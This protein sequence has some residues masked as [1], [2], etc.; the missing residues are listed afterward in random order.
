[1]LPEFENTSRN[2]WIAF[3]STQ[4]LVDLKFAVPK[5]SE[6]LYMYWI[7]PLGDARWPNLVALHRQGSVFHTP[8]WLE[9][10][11]RT[12]GYRPVALTSHPPGLE[13]LDGIPF[14]VVKSWITGSR[15]VSLPFSDHCQPLLRDQ[16][17][18]APFTECLR[19]NCIRSGWEYI[20]LRLKRPANLNE[21]SHD[22]PAISEGQCEEII[23]F[24]PGGCTSSFAKY[25]EYNFHRI[26]LRPDVDT[27]FR[28]FHKSCVQRK[29]H[30]AER[31][32]LEYEAGRSESNMMKFYRLLVMT[33]RRHGVPPQPISWFRN[34]IDCFGE[35]LTIHIA[36]KDDRPIAAI[37]T[38]L[39]R[40]TLVYKYGCSDA[41]FHRLG[42][43]PMLF[44][45]ALQKGK[46]QDVEEF[47]LGRSNRDNPGLAVFKER[48]GAT[49]SKLTYSRLGRVQ[50]P[51]PPPDPRSR[52]VNVMFA[53]MPSRVAQ[54][55]GRVMY[56]H[57]G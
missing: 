36:S 11:R 4:T 3:Q 42:A 31:E 25:A 49:R 50:S 20:E 9:A 14:C 55:A 38:L 26:D 52:L 7:N 2:E 13:L 23:P 51:A 45:K 22:N 28:N 43:M 35:N 53:R 37:L 44:W 16:G 6:R 18:L 8:S 46:Q 47:D 54:M 10:L 21:Q 30:R 41:A 27:L 17:D 39:Y 57:I 56:R 33:R 34:L 40:K 48:L 5:I 1:M 15:L 32:R 19:K 12:Y 29:I 24:R